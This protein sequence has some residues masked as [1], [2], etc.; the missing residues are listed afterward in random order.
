MGACDAIEPLYALCVGARAAES[1][2]VQ[3]ASVEAMAN[4]TATRMGMA[5]RHAHELHKLGVEP[6]VNLCGSVNARLQELA[7]LLLG[8]ISLNDKHR[9]AIVACDGVHALFSIACGALGAGN[10]DAQKNALWALGNLVWDVEAQ[11]VL[12]SHFVALIAL[13]SHIVE[14]V[15]S[16]ALNAVGN[17][18]FYHEPNRLRLMMIEDCQIS[19]LGLDD[20]PAEHGGVGVVAPVVRRRGTSSQMLVRRCGEPSP[21]VQAQAARTIGTAAYND[22]FSVL[23]GKAGAVQALVLLCDSDDAEVLEHAVFGL[24]NLAVHDANKTLLMG[25]GGIEALVKVRFVS[26]S[27]FIFF[28]AA[29]W[30]RSSAAPAPPSLS[31][32]S[33]ANP[34]HLPSLFFSPRPP[35]SCTATTW[36]RSAP[37]PPAPLRYS[38]TLRPAR[39]LSRKRWSSRWTRSS[40]C[41][42]R[43]TF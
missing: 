23:L 17:A 8:N 39:S 19:V 38:Q 10:I 2:N 28:C 31:R 36:R 29:G 25:A 27:F 40:S 3:A 35:P 12:G 13:C 22:D 7:P 32:R 42:A 33:R 9:R 15:R 21:R 43:T 1:E 18:L 16:A 11:S 34:L 4:L 6:L 14:D 41:C 26:F 30:R 20:F 5:E 24:S 37:T